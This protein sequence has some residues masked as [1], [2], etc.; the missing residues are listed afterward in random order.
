MSKRNPSRV[1]KS[2]WLLAA[3]SVAIVI[4]A[5][6][7]VAPSL[8]QEKTKGAAPGGLKWKALGSQVYFPKTH[9]HAAALAATKSAKAVQDGWELPV[10][11]MRAKVPGG[12]FVFVGDNAGGPFFYPDPEH[13]WDGSSL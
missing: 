8:A 11:A 4:G 13:R 12:W 7:T 6:L 1:P 9:H 2:T 10:T 3:S 5:V